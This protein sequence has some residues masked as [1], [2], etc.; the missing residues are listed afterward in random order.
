[1]QLKESIRARICTS[2]RHKT[3][4][5]TSFIHWARM[6]NEVAVYDVLREIHE[7]LQEEVEHFH[8]I[9]QL[10]GKPLLHHQLRLQWCHFCAQLQAYYCPLNQQ[11][12]VAKLH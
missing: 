9:S 3:V 11:Y 5:L 12:S 10:I 2:H 6:M 7:E 4:A 1:M 8:A